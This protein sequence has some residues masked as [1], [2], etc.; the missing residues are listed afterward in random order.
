MELWN[1]MVEQYCMYTLH[2]LYRTLVRVLV[3]TVYQCL[4]LCELQTD[5]YLLYVSFITVRCVFCIYC[6]E[7]KVCVCGYECIIVM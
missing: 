6:I 3:R 4:D 1:T 5:G 7:V 2:V